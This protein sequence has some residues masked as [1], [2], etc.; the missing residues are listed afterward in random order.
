M[1]TKEGY[2]DRTE[3]NSSE[4]KVCMATIEDKLEH[5]Q[6]G[7][8][9]LDGAIFALCEKLA[10]VLRDSSPLTAAN[11]T[12]V[13]SV[14]DERSAIFRKICT[15]EINLNENIDRLNDLYSKIEL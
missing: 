8:D 6:I 3:K 13:D 15:M 1:M 14:K 2:T 12:R 9:N 5:L 7:L 10:P 4:E 11:C